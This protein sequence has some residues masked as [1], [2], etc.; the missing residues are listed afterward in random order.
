MTVNYVE[1]QK[2]SLKTRRTIEP[3][4]TLEAKRTEIRAKDRLRKDETVSYPTGTLMVKEQQ[5]P[6]TCSRTR[7]QKRNYRGD[8]YKLADK[9]RKLN[10]QRER[11]PGRT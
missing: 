8:G 1:D 2:L 9:T 7:E 5:W 11:E 6:E 10:T 3:A 4:R